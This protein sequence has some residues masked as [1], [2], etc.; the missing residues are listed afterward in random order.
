MIKLTKLCFILLLLTGIA[1]TPKLTS[2]FA[3]KADFEALPE[4]YDAPV[5]GRQKA[6]CND[7][8][9]Y[10]PDTSHLDHTPIKYVRINVHWVNNR[11]SSVNFVGEEAVE[12]TKLLLHASNYNLIGNK[13]LWL[14]NGNDIPLLPIQ[15]RLV[16]AGRPGDPDDDARDAP[17]ARNARDARDARDARAGEVGNHPVSILGLP[18]RAICTLGRSRPDYGAI[19]HLLTSVRPPASSLTK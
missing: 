16:L 11:D 12:F 4:A 17:E 2:R 9:A 18:R 13:K 19:T 5:A 7:Y 10:I 8:E 6:V 3:G 14:P 15:Y 1:C